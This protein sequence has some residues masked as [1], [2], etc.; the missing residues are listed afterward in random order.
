M[1]RDYCEVIHPLSYIP[2]MTHCRKLDYTPG[3]VKKED[4]IEKI[5]WVKMLNKTTIIQT[6]GR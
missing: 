1:V 6:D 4:R 5:T 3:G 2:C